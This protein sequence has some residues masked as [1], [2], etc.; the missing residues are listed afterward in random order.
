M[1]A[2]VKTIAEHCA[3]IV[4]FV[5]VAMLT[6]M[7]LYAIGRA[8][9]DLLRG[10]PRHVIWKDARHQLGSS[11]LLGLEFLVAADIIHTVAVE[12]TYETVIVLALIVIIRTMLSF[13]IEVELT[14]HWPWQNQGQSVGDSNRDQ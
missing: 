6:L 10:R 12:L 14:G 5:G 4:E 2:W 3:A 13:A 9:V 1:R 8:V 11:I 7:T